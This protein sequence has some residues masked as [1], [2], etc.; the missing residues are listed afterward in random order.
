VDTRVRGLG[1]A[2]LIL[3]L[4][5]VPLHGSFPDGDPWYHLEKGFSLLSVEEVSYR[6][7]L[8]LP[9]HLLDRAEL[10]RLSLI[11]AGYAEPG[12]RSGFREGRWWSCDHFQPGFTLIQ[13]AGTGPNACRLIRDGLQAAA[14]NRA[15]SFISSWGMEAFLTGQAGDLTL[16]GM[17]LLESLGGRLRS[18][19]V[20]H[21]AVHF[22]AD[23]PWTDEKIV[24]AEGP[25]NLQLELYRDPLTNRVR[26][27]A[28]VP[29]IISLSP[30]SEPLPP[31]EL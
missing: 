18:T 7:Y 14:G 24:L 21:G 1:L 19:A 13:V 16:L 31:S 29:V 27:R 4:S 11:V 26:V 6:G 23:V 15:R 2:C 25:V 17:E 28:G 5:C 12:E 22:L 9:D 20:Y 8:F 30:F 3:F 10:S